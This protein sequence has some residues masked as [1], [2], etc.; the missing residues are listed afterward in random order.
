MTRSEC[1]NDCEF[2]GSKTGLHSPHVRRLTSWLKR[3]ALAN[4]KRATNTSTHVMLTLLYCNIFLAYLLDESP[5]WCRNY[6]DAVR[7][8]CCRLADIAKQHDATNNHTHFPSQF[9]PA[10]FPRCPFFI[11]AHF[12]DRVPVMPDHIRGQIPR[13]ADGREPCLRF[14]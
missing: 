8:S 5:E 10:P 1:L 2:Y 14:M 11:E 3:F 7:L 9:D 13:D 4:K 12:A 6:C